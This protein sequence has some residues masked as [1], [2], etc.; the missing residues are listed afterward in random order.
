MYFW[1]CGLYYFYSTNHGVVFVNHAMICKD[2]AV[3][4]R[5]HD[6]NQ[7]IDTD[8]IIFIHKKISLFNRIFAYMRL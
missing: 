6:E 5:I 1:F 4:Y 7:G 8:T 3:V 2:H